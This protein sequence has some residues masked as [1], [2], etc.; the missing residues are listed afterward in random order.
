MTID[1]EFLKMHGAAM[2]CMKA[3]L[4]KELSNE[5]Q[6]L[7]C[8]VIADKIGMHRRTVDKYVR[9]LIEMGFY[10]REMQRCVTDGVSGTI[11]SRCYYRLTQK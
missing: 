2:A 9:V 10:E 6:V 5:W 4:D 3:W 11:G 1:F 8:A 7:S